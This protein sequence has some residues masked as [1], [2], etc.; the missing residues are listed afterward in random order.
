MTAEPREE[1]ISAYLDGELAEGERAEVEKLLAENSQLRQLH[2]ELRALRAGM[3]SLERHQL[4]RDLSPAVLRRAEQSVLR[5]TAAQGAPTRTGA[6]RAPVSW[7]NRGVGWR[8]VVWPAVA[9]AAAL[10]ILV[11][12][13]NQRP[14]ERQ[15]AQTRE[16]E[17][18]A[19]Q[20]GG[21]ADEVGAPALEAAPQPNEELDRVASLKLRLDAGRGAKSMSQPSAQPPAAGVRPAEPSA[22]EVELGRRPPAAE[23]L[24]EGIVLEVTPEYLLAKSFEKMLDQKKIKWHRLAAGDSRDA[25]A[26]DRYFEQENKAAARDK[27]SHA[28]HATYV[29]EADPAQ[30]DALLSGLK[31]RNRL[32][33]DVKGLF[34]QI[35][36][37]RQKSAAAAAGRVTVI[38]V[39]PPAASAPAAAEQP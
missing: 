36:P 18:I 7:W 15:V 37:P 24:A 8:R 21:A 5:G 14:A 30:V 28:L 12:D 20:I 39:A 22:A 3:Q 27:K 16:S 13:A 25:G 1:L 31:L 11:Y 32:P 2:D 26:N 23:E 9:I 29:L 19:D 17:Q 33:A 4:D 34:R 6:T 35:T 10:A 38:L